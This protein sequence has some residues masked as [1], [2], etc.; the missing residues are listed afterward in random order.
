MDGVTKLPCFS[1]SPCLYFIFK[2]VTNSF[3]GSLYR[4]FITT[5]KLSFHHY[6]VGKYAAQGKQPHPKPSN[7]L[8]SPTVT[9]P[10]QYPSPEKPKVT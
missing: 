3:G 4:D 2:L 7:A 8:P 1:G 5:N 9:M 10:S 6:S